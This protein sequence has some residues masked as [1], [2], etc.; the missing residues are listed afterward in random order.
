MLE[1]QQKTQVQ[2][3][4][5]DFKIKALTAELAYYRRV[6]FG[7]KSE[8]FKGEQRDLFEETVDADLSESFSYPSICNPRRG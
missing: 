3:A 2:I 4:E 1:I 7:K 8:A 6:Q 5:K